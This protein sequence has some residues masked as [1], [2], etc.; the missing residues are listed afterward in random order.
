MIDNSHITGNIIG[1]AHS[2]RNSKVK[3][4]KNEI[5][6]I[7]DNLFAFDFF[8]FLKDLRLGAWKTTNL[9]IG[10]KNLTNINFAKISD[11][12]KFIDTV[13]YFQQ[14]LSALSSS[15]IDEKKK[16][17]RTE[18]Q[19][20]IKNDPKLNKNSFA[21][22]EADRE[23]VLD[24]LF[25]GKRIIPYEMRQRPDSLDIAPKKGT[26]FTSSFL[27]YHPRKY[28]SASSF[29]SCLHRDKNKSLVTL[30]TNSEDVLLFE[31]TLI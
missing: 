10:G 1:Y 2:F 9:F 8:F 30:P 25:S 21:C 15:M 12:V 28:H 3:E 16:G 14:S 6:A 31:R 20:F 17:I 26:F 19:R 22:S 13:K 11:Q 27:L 23:L 7:A 24:Y 18:C 5:S 29:S 4:N